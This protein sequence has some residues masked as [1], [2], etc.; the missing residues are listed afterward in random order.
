MDLAAESNGRR[1]VQHRVAHAACSRTGSGRLH[2]FVDARA[3]PA[4]V[5]DRKPTS[6]GAAARR[7]SVRDVESMGGPARAVI[8]GRCVR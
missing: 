8:D 4:H 2:R 7:K 3:R 1:N 6:A 5:T